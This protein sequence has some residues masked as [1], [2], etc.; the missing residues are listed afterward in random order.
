[1]S[2]RATAWMRLDGPS[3]T[4]A[5]WSR[6]DAVGLVIVEENVSEALECLNKVDD[7]KTV[8]A[9][10]RK[11]AEKVGLQ[12][13]SAATTIRPLLAEAQTALSSVVGTDAG[14]GGA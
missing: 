5:A 14:A 3:S 4:V 12:A 2:D 11:D 7:L 6:V 10:I 13:T 1:M 9:R 8:S